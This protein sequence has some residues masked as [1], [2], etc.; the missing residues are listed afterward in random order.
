AKGLRGTAGDTLIGG[1]GRLLVEGEDF[2]IDEPCRLLLSP[3]SR[4]LVLLRLRHRAG[5][6]A[7][8]GTV[9]AVVSRVHRAS[10]ISLSTARVFSSEGI[11][12]SPP[13]GTEGI[14]RL[15]LRDRADEGGEPFSIHS[16]GWDPKSFWKADRTARISSSLPAAHSKIK[17]VFDPE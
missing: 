8:L 7:H 14:S 11:V 10:K 13:H 1:Q 2:L 12:K 3:R 4:G 6:V 9:G 5:E 17:T 16:E 15:I